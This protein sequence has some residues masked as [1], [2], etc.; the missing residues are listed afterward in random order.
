M[1]A[2]RAGIAVP[3]LLGVLLMN[4]QNT[5][6]REMNAKIRVEGLEHSQAMPVFET[7]TI[8]IGPRL[9]G[10][11]AFKR[12]IDFARDRLQAYGLANVHLEPWKFGRG[13]TLEHLTVEMVEPRYMPLIG[14]AE[15]WSPSTAG[16]LVAAPL[17]L[18]GKTPEQIEAVRASI[19]GAIV[20]TQPIQTAFV[21]QDRPQP[22]E[23]SANAP[24]VLSPPALFRATPEAQKITTLVRE[25]GPGVMIRPNVLGDGTVYVT[26][27]DAGPSGVPS[28]VLASEHYNL[29]A[30][31][32]EH[33]VAVKLRVNIQSK[34]Y[35]TDLNAYNLIGE[36]P[37]T[38]LKDQVVMIGA[39]IDS[40]HTAVGATDNA[41][42]TTTM[43]E[44]MR[45]LKAAGA[46]PRRTIRVG[47]WGGEEQGLL[48][49]K[50]WVA[51]HLAGDANRQARENLA[52]YFNIDNGTGPIYGFALENNADARPILDA[53]L[54]PFKDLGARR[55]VNLHLT[56]T[57][58]LSFLAVG[59]PAFNPFQDY[60]DYDVR[61]HHT[62][63]DSVEH[64]EP[65]DL[66]QAAIVMASFAYHAAMRDQTVPRPQGA[67]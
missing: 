58:H 36:I 13:W 42:G 24:E 17:F 46:R 30:R 67:R 66:R 53:W 50:A 8:E 18:G 51:Q 64:V 19:K 21:R 7:L 9:T 47:I 3:G 34:Y 20:M 32:L 65:E 4:G 49:S 5:V 60:Q 12:A 27:R 38:D 26:G 1:I 39:H 2:R 63:M 44:A 14:Y 28:I 25:S 37:G 10:S 43:I 62:N 48:G 59:V 16:D 29:I 33:K 6:D 57:D 22:T 11:P 52:V 23:A 54:E 55:N 31:M 40:W 15:G 56:D 45:I 41:D 35:E 61:T